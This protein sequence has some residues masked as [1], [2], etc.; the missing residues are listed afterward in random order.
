MRKIRIACILQS[1]VVD[2][3]F[4]EA[5]AKR[6]D[7]LKE[8]LELLDQAGAGKPDM[9]VLSEAFADGLTDLKAEPIDGPAVAGCR[10]LA[11]RHSMNVIAPIVMLAEDGNTY[12]TA[13]VI[14]RKGEIVGNYCKNIP[15]WGEVGTVPGNKIC[16]FDMDFGVIGVAICF[17][18]QWPDVWMELGAMGAEVVFW[19]SAYSGGVKLQ[20]PAIYNNF[21]VVSCT[22]L[23][24]DTTVID[25]N[26]E[27]LYHARGPHQVV[28]HEIDLD[29]TMVH[30][31]F[32]G[33]QLAQIRKDFEGRVRMRYM[34]REGWWVVESADPKVSVRELLEEYKAETL[35]DYTQRSRREIYKLREEGRPLP[36]LAT[37][38][39]MPE[40]V[41]NAP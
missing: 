40:E 17:E 22:T 41:E 39:G 30:D 18:S 7:C 27:Q 4:N 36:P 21:Y 25:I 15:F 31:N 5:V 3:A 14:D 16:V 6:E 12:N 2:G 24:P 34:H 11:R 10:E 32:N 29:R 23:P 13:V 19:P 33:A 8:G 9:A 37:E 20:A 28:F 26:G 1:K 35:R 38:P